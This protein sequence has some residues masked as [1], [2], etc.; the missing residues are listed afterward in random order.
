M[1]EKVGIASLILITLIIL[2]STGMAALFLTGQSRVLAD[3]VSGFGGAD[4]K[5]GIR[6]VPL[7]LASGLEGFVLI[8]TTNYKLCIYEY[9]MR[10]KPH[11]R[12][13]LVA[14]RNFRYDCQLE[15]YNNA[16]P[17]PSQVKEWVER[18]GNE[19]PDVP[20]EAEKHVVQ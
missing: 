14:V 13:C 12:L 16:E 7:Q 10:R 19:S 6:V 9:D 18:G 1:P 20:K 5:T 8:D 4:E 3:P 15:D 11:E 17:R 2:F